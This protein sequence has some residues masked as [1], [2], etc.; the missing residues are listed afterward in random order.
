M[1]LLTQYKP[2]SKYLKA[3]D[4]AA[5]GWEWALTIKGVGEAEFDD[6][7][8]QPTLTFVETEKVLGLNRTNLETL[9]ELFGKPNERGVM[10]VEPSDLAGKIVSAFKTQ[11]R[12]S[13]GTMV[14]CVRLRMPRIGTFNAMTERP[15]QTPQPVS[16]TYEQQKAAS[17]ALTWLDSK[18]V[19]QLTAEDGVTVRTLAAVIGADISGA[20]GIRSAAAIIRAQANKIAETLTVTLKPGTED[21][22]F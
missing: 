14:D 5:H 3:E 16:Y 1:G 8:R 7:R 17:D 13:G 20:K 10:D 4:L 18:P 2:E 12:N 21:I 6:G 15:Q 22:P 11:T 19:E 9:A